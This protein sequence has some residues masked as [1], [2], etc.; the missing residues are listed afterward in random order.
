VPTS[1]EHKLRRQV[2]TLSEFGK[3]ALRSD[4]INGLLQEATRLVSEAVD[5]GLVKVLELRPGGES[6]RVRAGVNWNPGVVGHAE[7]P[8]HEGSSAGYALRTKTPVITHDTMSETRFEIPELLIEHG[9]RSTVNVV[10]QGEDNAFGVF[11]VDSRE[12]RTFSQDDIDFLQNY[13]NLLAS[14]IDRVRRQR[15]LAEQAFRQEMLGHELQHRINN[16]VTMIQAIARRMRAKSQSL[17]EF[18]KAFDARLTAIARTHALLSRSRASAIDIRDVLLQELSVHGAVEGENLR[19][20]GPHLSIP[21]KKAE[22]LSMAIHELVTNAVKHGA[23]STDNGYIDVSWEAHDR[24]N[25]RE[26]QICWRE[27]GVATAPESARRGFGSEFLERLI[28]QMLRGRFER[29]FHSDGIECI[30][31]FLMDENRI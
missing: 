22:L 20:Y 29:T 5:V 18:A 27:R 24:G 26:I 21:A 4:D 23:L 8:A 16:M 10:I 6:L 17:D 11:E 9:V 3:Q 13:A 1:E 19:Q 7:I 28:P 30:M 31:S 12:L 15:E 25:E 2:S 14:A